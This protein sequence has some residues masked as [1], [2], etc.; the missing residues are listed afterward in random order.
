MDLERAFHEDI[1]AHPD[2]PTPW[3]ILADWLQE[4]DDPRGEL[5]RLWQSMRLEPQ[6]ADAQSRRERMN[7]LFEQGVTLS[8]PRYTNTIGMEFV[9]VSP[10]VFWMGGSDGVPATRQLTV[11]SPYW[12]SLYPITQHQWQTLQG[13]N[14]CYFSRSGPG[15]SQV[16]ELTDA[17]LARFP[18]EQV[19]FEETALFLRSLNEREQ[20]LGWS[21]RLPTEMEWE[22]ACRSPVHCAEDCSYSYYFAM[23]TNTLNPA[24]GNYTDSGLMR[25]TPVGSYRPNRLG[26]YDL[27]GTIDEWCPDP[28]SPSYGLVR[29]GSWNDFGFRCTA[30]VR[31]HFAVDRH[32]NSMGFRPVRVR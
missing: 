7:E 15:A 1:V 14:P 18:V 12:M 17:E 16:S 11:A 32:Y 8:Q 30:A 9:W 26:I 5:V 29:G 28:E 21:Y 3:L 25:P 2:D 24:D 6:H 31:Y 27:H 20:S 13:N 23:P 10:G 19:S 22:F 4:Q